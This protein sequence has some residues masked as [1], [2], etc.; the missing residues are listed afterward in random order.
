ME[1]R[2]LRKGS[3]K[4]WKSKGVEICKKPNI[5]NVSQQNNNIDQ[6][7]SNVTEQNVKMLFEGNNSINDVDH[8]V[9]A[10]FIDKYKTKQGLN[11]ALLKEYGSEKTGLINKIIKPLIK[12]KKGK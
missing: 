10:N 12:D 11:N 4:Y 8:S 7:A 3:S 5:L 9:V 2:T 1:Y 6:P